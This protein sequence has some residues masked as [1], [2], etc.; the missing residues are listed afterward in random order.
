MLEVLIAIVEHHVRTMGDGCESPLQRPI[1][2]E[3]AGT[4][5]IGSRRPRIGVA[6]RSCDRGNEDVGIAG[7]QPDVRVDLAMGVVVI[8]IVAV[9]GML[10]A[11]LVLPGVLAFVSRVGLRLLMPVIIRL[12]RAAFACR[13]EIRPGTSHSSTA[14]AFP[15]ALAAA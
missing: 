7:I 13:K 9:S 14:L 3:G 11:V 15:R 1:N 12:R 10:A 8:R 6:W 2:L 4:G 5:L